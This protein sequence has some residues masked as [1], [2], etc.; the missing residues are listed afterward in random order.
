MSGFLG[1][2]NTVT[3]TVNQVGAIAGG[4]GRLASDVGGLLSGNFGAA[5]GYGAIAP[6][7]GPWAARLQPASWRG[8][9]FA[10]AE[11]EIRTGRRT[12]VHEYPYRDAVWVEDLGLGTQTIGFRGFLIGDDVYSQRDAMI[13]AA[14]QPGYGMLV[15]PSLGSLTVALVEFTAGERMESGRVVGLQ[16]GFIKT[17]PAVLYPSILT[18]TGS[19]VGLAADSALSGFGSDFGTDVASAIG[20]GAAVVQGVVG[21]VGGFVNQAQRIVGDASMIAHSVSGL[22]GG[23]FGRYAY[24]SRGVLQTLTTASAAIS[25]VTAATTA[26]R[27]A[28]GSVMN[29]AAAL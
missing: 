5:G 9:P 2:L 11:S 19:A 25:Q 21:T 23:S 1:A 3:R 27:G 26:V 15:H 8:I 10:V 24:G 4:V 29:L 16:F 20:H 18:S 13:A 6:G 7:L 28:A 14:Q 22:A 12:A 17:A